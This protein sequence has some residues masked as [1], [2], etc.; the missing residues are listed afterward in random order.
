VGSARTSGC[1][2]EKL[3][4]LRRRRAAALGILAMA[5]RKLTLTGMALVAGVALAMAVPLGGGLEVAQASQEPRFAPIPHS[6]A[7]D[8]VVPAPND[9]GFVGVLLAEQA[10]DLACGT[11]GRLLEVFPRIGQAVLE[12]EILARLDDRE[13]KIKLAEAEAALDVARAQLRRAETETFDARLRLAR[14]RSVATALSTEELESAVHQERISAARG[15]EA[16]AAE[17]EQ[18]AKVAR[19]RLELAQTIVRAPFA[20]VIAAR[21]LDPGTSVQAQTAVVRVV[22]A[23]HPFLRFAVPEERAGEVRAGSQVEASLEGFGRLA[24]ATVTRVAPEIE[25]ST[26]T[27]FAEARIDSEMTI[28]RSLRIGALARIRVLPPPI[29]SE[30]LHP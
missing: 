23:A 28:L 8:A 18:E 7:P 14:R 3:D 6:R 26:R 13:A 24:P 30:G 20:G 10:A 12:G 1:L 16:R 4:A 2:R 27:I 29:E 15:S 22:A 9:E 21:Y 17:R 5:L 25:S 19:L 11:E